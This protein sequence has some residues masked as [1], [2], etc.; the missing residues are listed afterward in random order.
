MADDVYSYRCIFII[1]AFIFCYILP[2]LEYGALFFQAHP[3]RS[4]CNPRDPHLLDGVEIYNGNPRHENNNR[5]A[6]KWAEKYHLMVSSGSDFHQL[7]D[8]GLGGIIL[9]TNVQDSRELAAVLKQGT[10]ELIQTP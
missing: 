1:S 3:C 7:E 4:Y 5:R 6:K 10:A 2:A 9:S 8:A